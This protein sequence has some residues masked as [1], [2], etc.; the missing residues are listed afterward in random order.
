[1]PTGV[2]LQGASG[3]QQE[4]DRRFQAARIAV[5]PLEYTSVGQVLGHYRVKTFVSAQLWALGAKL[6]ALRWTD[7]SRFFVLLRMGASTLVTSAVT[8]QVIGTLTLSVVRGYTVRDSTNAT[9]ITWTGKQQ[10]MRTTMGPSLL[11]SGSGN[12]DTASAA[13]G[14]SGGS[15]SVDTDGIG[16]HSV[17]SLAGVGSG[18]VRT[19]LFVANVSNG[20]HPLVLAQYEGLNLFWGGVALASGAVEIDLDLIWAEVVVY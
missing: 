12:I 14:L 20:E 9:P 13:A 8:A 7:P 1:M 11:M 17:T 2:Y 16:Y 3:Y 18:T 10:T 6:M 15:S 19:D 4:V 5:W